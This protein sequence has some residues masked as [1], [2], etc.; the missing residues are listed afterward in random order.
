MNI[1]LI[2][3]HQFELGCFE[4]FCQDLLFDGVSGC[5]ELQCPCGEISS[6]W[7]PCEQWQSCSVLAK[8]STQMLPWNDWWQHCDNTGEIDHEGIPKPNEWCEF[9][10]FLWMLLWCWQSHSWA[11]A[12]WLYWV[13]VWQLLH[14]GAQRLGVFRFS[15]C[16]ELPHSFT[17]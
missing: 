6:I 11:F 14:G 1:N 4:I 9:A 16:S 5:A 7:W 17:T 3:C 12:D 13:G 15:T 10:I 8:H 2:G